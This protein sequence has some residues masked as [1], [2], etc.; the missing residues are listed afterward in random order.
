LVADVMKAGFSGAEWARL[1]LSERIALCH[2]YAR[3]AAQLAD[4]ATPEMRPK[5][6]AVAAQW[7][8][9]AAEIEEAGHEEPLG[10]RS[11]ES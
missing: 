1:D 7:N 8:T 3:E 2:I 9:L 10:S 11:R 4:A 6:K 5:Y